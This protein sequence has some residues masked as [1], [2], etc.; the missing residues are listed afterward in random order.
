MNNLKMFQNV[1]GTAITEV[2]FEIYDEIR[3][4]IHSRNAGSYS[5]RK[6]V[7]NCF[8]EHERSRCSL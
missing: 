1:S 2:R 6:N 7:V 4:V 8:S 3:K 5:V